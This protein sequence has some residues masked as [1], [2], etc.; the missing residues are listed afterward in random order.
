MCRAFLWLRQRS[1]GGPPTTFRPEQ[2]H[3]DH[4][5]E[6]CPDEKTEDMKGGVGGVHDAEGN[7]RADGTAEREDEDGG[8]VEEEDEATALGAF[9]EHADPKEREPQQDGGEGGGDAESG[10]SGAKTLNE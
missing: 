1:V 2:Q 10:G 8:K 4:T 9:Q 6:D 7:S 5:A 3:A